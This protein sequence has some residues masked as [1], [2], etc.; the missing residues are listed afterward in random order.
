MIFNMYIFANHICKYVYIVIIHVYICICMSILVCAKI[1]GKTIENTK[2]CFPG[3]GLKMLT[4][5]IIFESS[6]LLIVLGHCRV[7]G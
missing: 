5:S 6:H 1:L 3:S 2:F 7:R 4:R